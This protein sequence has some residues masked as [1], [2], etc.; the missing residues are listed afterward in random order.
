MI[1]NTIH[2]RRLILRAPTPAD[3]HAY[4]TKIDDFAVA[5]TLTPVAH[6]YSETMARDYLSALPANSEHEAHFI[7]EM[8]KRGLIGSV[9]ISN[10]IGYWIARTFWGKGIATEAITAALAWYFDHSAEIGIASSVHANNYASRAIQEKLGFQEVGFDD[11]FCLAQQKTIKHITT[12]L[13]RNDFQERG[14]AS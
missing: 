8:P 13:D 6:P 2:T 12:F 14:E 7:I 11:R 4:A 10:E 1:D 5:K 3:A 9:S